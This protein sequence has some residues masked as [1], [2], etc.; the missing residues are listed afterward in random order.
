MPEYTLKELLELDVEGAKKLVHDYIGPDKTEFA[1]TVSCVVMC[2][3]PVDEKIGEYAE[4][5]AKWIPSHE[6]Y[7]EPLKEKAEKIAHLY[8]IS[9]KNFPTSRNY[10]ALAC[11]YIASQIDPIL[12]KLTISVIGDLQHYSKEE[13]RLLKL[14]LPKKDLNFSENWLK[15]PK[16]YIKSIV[17]DILAKFTTLQDIDSLL[18]N[19]SYTPVKDSVF[20][21]VDEVYKHYSD[22]VKPCSASEIEKIDASEYKKDLDSIIERRQLLLAARKAIPPKVKLVMF[23]GDHCLRKNYTDILTRYSFFSEPVSKHGVPPSKLA[24]LESLEKLGLIEY[25]ED[26]KGYVAKDQELMKNIKI[27]AAKK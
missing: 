12:P 11:F 20:Q 10:V 15:T 5:I 27:L 8:L 17:G 9:A 23:Y 25:N 2:H 6:K 24:R 16:N 7:L 21:L 22:F 26:K 1:K 4:L 14:G 3:K 13:K 18:D 19:F